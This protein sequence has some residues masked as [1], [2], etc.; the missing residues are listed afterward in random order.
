MTDL[1][2]YTAMKYAGDCKCGK[3]QLVPRHVL[4]ECIA[5]RDVLVKALKTIAAMDPKG[6]RADD[7]GR[8][9]RMASEAIS[10]F[11]G[12]SGK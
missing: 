10:A 9:A 4:D 2:E 12:G 7:L 1:R 3:C 8:A 6:I 5:E 11:V